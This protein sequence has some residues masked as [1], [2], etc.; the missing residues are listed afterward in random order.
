MGPV[1]ELTNLGGTAEV[2]ELLGC[3]K[4]QIH[5]LRKKAEFPTPVLLLAA[6]PIWKLS[7]IRMFKETWKRRPRHVPSL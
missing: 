4:Q 1:A 5:A 3:P 2:A 7:D 6:S